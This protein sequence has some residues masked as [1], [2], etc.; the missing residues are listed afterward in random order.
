MFYCRVMYVFYS[1]IQI[2]CLPTEKQAGVE[3]KFSEEF[4]KSHFVALLRA[5]AWSSQC[6]K[7]LQF[8]TLSWISATVLWILYSQSHASAGK[9]ARIVFNRNEI[10]WSVDF[11][12]QKHF[13]QSVLAVMDQP[14]KI[15]GEE[16]LVPGKEIL[17][18]AKCNRSLGLQ[19]AAAFCILQVPYGRSIHKAAHGICIFYRTSAFM[20]IITFPFIVEFVCICLSFM[21]GAA[22]QYPTAAAEWTFPSVTKP[23][24]TTRRWFL[25]LAYPEECCGQLVRKSWPSAASPPS[26][27][28]LAASV[29]S[30]VDLH[31][32]SINCHFRFMFR[33]VI[34]HTPNNM[35][36]GMDKIVLLGEWFNYSAL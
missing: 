18:A 17:I 15:T 23:M 13:V 35:H 30:S 1:L 20:G 21:A 9:K 29:P 2:Y 7:L 31:P 16:Q 6:G 8:I 28:W 34:S 10:L 27:A 32:L 24:T 14:S 4:P 36:L 33:D 3:I 25:S 22:W 5:G 19:I 26:P 11:L 12:S